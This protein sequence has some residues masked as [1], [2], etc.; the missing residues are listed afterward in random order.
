MAF[1]DFISQIHKKTERNYLQRV[2]DHDKAECARISKEFGKDYFDG[3]RKYGYGGLRYDG[4]WRPFAEKLAAHYNLKSG[5]K[6]LD[7]GCAKGFL[8]YEIMQVVSGIEVVGVDV[9]QYAIENAVPEVKPFLQVGNATRLL[10]PDHAY[11]L[12]LSINTL[13]NLYNFLLRTALQE[14]ERVGKS[15][16]YVVVDSYR[17][18]K[19]KVNLMYWQLTCECF[20]TPEEWKWFF[21]QS[22][23][24]GDYDFVFFE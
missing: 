18:E 22:G 9:S 17:N 14:L 8:L 12:V 23:Y 24:K 20:Y 10:F 21:D 16:K 19:E 15:N 13:H 1:L 5:D 4:R 6:V 3:D 7:V 11:D 2:V